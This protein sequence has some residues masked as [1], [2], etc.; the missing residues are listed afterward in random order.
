MLFDAGVLC[1]DTTV[2]MMLL[3]ALLL[4]L[5]AL[6]TPHTPIGS[7]S[8]IGVLKDMGRE[9]FIL[10]LNNLHEFHFGNWFG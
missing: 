4:A 10:L 7:R 5:R 9:L 3:L 6:L 2:D 1:V 8:R